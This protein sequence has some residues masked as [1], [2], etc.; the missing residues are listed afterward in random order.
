MIRNYLKVA[1]RQAYHNLG[2]TLI[3][4]SGLAIGITVCLLISLFIWDERQY[5]DFHPEKEQI[6]RITAERGG[7]G[8]L[9]SWA[10][11]S[12]AIGPALVEDFPEVESSVRFFKI[13]QKLLFKKEEESYLEEKGFFVENTIFDFFHL[14]F[15]FGQSASA[16]LE[17][18]TVVLT[19]SLATKYFGNENPVGQQ[20]KIGQDEV[21]VT[22]VL[23]DLS[24]HFHLEF[25]YLLSFENLL[26]Q[27]SEERINSWVWQDFYTYIKVYPNTETTLLSQ[28]LRSY[29]EQHAHPQTKK[30]GF[31]YYLN[32]Q[33][34]SDVHLH[35]SILRNDVAIR[36]NYRYVS[37]LAL[38]GIFLLLI[39]CINFINLSTAKASK[40]ANEVGI[41]KTS[42]ALGGQLRYQFLLEATFIVGIAM[43]IAIPLTKL[44]LPYLSDFTNKALDFSVLT[45]PAILLL[46]VGF[47][48]FIGLFA[49]SYPAFVL[50]AF[51]PVTILK[52]GQLNSSS[53]V[54]WLR[55]GLVITQF[56]LSILLI[57]C[58]LIISQQINFLNHS[59]LGFQ[60]EQLIHFPMKGNMF[61][62]MESA[63]SEFMRIPGVSS[64]ST[65][66]GIPGDIIAGD[67]I[68]VPGENR[69]NLPARIFT[70]DHE[71]IETMGM[72]IIA[73]RDFSKAITTDATEAFVIN[74]TAIAELGIASNPEEAIG[75]R[76][77]WP[78]WTDH[79]TLKIGTIIGVI[80]D[81]HYA[82]LH[83]TI[84]SVVLQIYPDSYWKMA[85]RLNTE[86]LV[87]TIAAI[88]NTW[89][90]FDSGYP[91]DYQFVDT[92]FGAM[93][94]E[95][96]KLSSLLLIFTALAIFI[97]CIGAFGLAVFAT[98]QRRKEIGIRKVLGASVGS[99]INLLSKDFLRLIW[100]SLVFSLPIAW[101]VMN[102]WLADFAYQIKMQ[103]W[104]FGIAGFLTIL[105][106]LLT[107]GSQ[108][109]KAALA[110][111]VRALRSE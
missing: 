68:I 39:A 29:V 26:T 105:I 93:Y 13:R 66:F 30:Q 37:G 56:T 25:D 42:G 45:S 2:T 15:R 31:Y 23:E 102:A 73:G 75:Q 38:V 91:I 82:S 7:E 107:V 65:C 22:G 85:L 109:I 78:M 59:D 48:L 63:K 70:V 27:V 64:A 8:G 17:P 80:K 44:T 55:K 52:G 89:N 40:R 92:G 10:S 69:R 1:W 6:Y 60:K 87:G 110:N 5:D 21:K 79:D 86:D 67:G 108:S 95:E 53:H 51:Q 49:G 58:V 19:S 84:Q 96:Q 34:L 94:A 28:K 18:N 111:P 100:I 88:E 106:V 24:P 3:N 71:Y 57:S 20:L 9:A 50:S 54:N 11:C 14:P 46:L 32:L 83:E 12:P 98:E 90:S 16:L 77:E 81:F 35:S 62:N 43:L 41:R 101:L 99:I 72:E 104:M 47:T 36:G 33:A 103:W 4:I 61:G 76:L 97:S 74:E